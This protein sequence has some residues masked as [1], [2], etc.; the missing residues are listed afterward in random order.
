M[1]EGEP[2]VTTAAR[3]A[4]ASWRS[5][6]RV[7]GTVSYMLRHTMSKPRAA[8]PDCSRGEEGGGAC[9]G[10]GSV[11]VCVCVCV[12]VRAVVACATWHVQEWG[13]AAPRPCRTGWAP[14]ELLL[15]A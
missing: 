10:G 6:R 7:T 8:R 15:P 2:T 9:C 4:A 5:S 11:C 14:R 3:L 1:A 12:C 13:G